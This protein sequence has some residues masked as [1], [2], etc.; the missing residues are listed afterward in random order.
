MGKFVET[1]YGGQERG[2][3]RKAYL[4]KTTIEK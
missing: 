4:R 3:N 2:T 1:I